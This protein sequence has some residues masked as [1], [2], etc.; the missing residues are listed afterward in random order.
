MTG[1]GGSLKRSPMKKTVAKAPA[2][3]TRSF[4]AQLEAAVLKRHCANHP[5]TEKWA[6]GKVSRN[7][8]M[9]WAVEHYHWV[10]KMGP[11]FL[12]ICVNAPP[13]VI[14][15]T[16]KNWAEETDEDHSHLDIVLRFAEANGADIAKVKQGRGLPTTESWVRFL[17][18]ACKR[19]P[20][21]VGVAATNIG[22]ESQSPMLYGKMLPSLRTIY[23]YPERDIE[24]FWLHVDADADHGDRAFAA[25]ERHCTTNALRELALYWAYE[26]ARMRWLHFDGIFLHYEMGYNLADG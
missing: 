18:D 26:S 12:S 5:L 21:I 16:L 3:R 4:R 6:S 25:L 20:W 7:A 2:V 8:R 24:H 22:T 14:G 17:L 13:D 23:R 1:T 10:S 11:A 19:E 15:F 9:G